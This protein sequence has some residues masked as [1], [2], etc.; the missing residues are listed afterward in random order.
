MKSSKVPV[1]LK[2]AGAAVFAA[3]VFGVALIAD[4]GE[5]YGGDGVFRAAFI[6]SAGLLFLASVLALFQ[7]AGDD[8]WFL[9]KRRFGLG[10][11]AVPR[12]RVHEG[13]ANF[14][15]SSNMS[16][17]IDVIKSNGEVVTLPPLRPDD[18]VS[19]RTFVREAEKATGEHHYA[20]PA[21]SA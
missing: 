3:A 6:L 4:V 21:G 12:G 15:A 20:S 13:E 18:K 7:E 1:R 11:P 8:V 17:T 2:L 9:L 19:I 16:V 5:L 14:S 10:R